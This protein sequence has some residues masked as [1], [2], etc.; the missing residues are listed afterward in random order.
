MNI[1]CKFSPD[2]HMKILYETYLTIPCSIIG[3]FLQ[4]P[5]PLA[6]YKRTS[7]KLFM[8]YPSSWCDFQGLMLLSEGVFGVKKMSRYSVTASVVTERFCLKLGRLY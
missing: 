3:H 1:I 5:P 7:V 4:C 6:E 2:E 8:P